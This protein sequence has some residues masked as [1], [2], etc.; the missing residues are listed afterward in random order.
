MGPIR[1]AGYRPPRESFV[2]LKWAKEM[3]MMIM[4]ML[5]VVLVMRRMVVGT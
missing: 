3:M 2:G 1:H 5:M 4:V